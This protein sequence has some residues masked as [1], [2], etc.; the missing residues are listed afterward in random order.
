[1]FWNLVL[2]NLHSKKC[3]NVF[4]K[5]LHSFMRNSL[6]MLEKQ[7]SRKIVFMYYKEKFLKTVAIHLVLVVNSSMTPTIF[8]LIS[9]LGPVWICQKQ[10]DMRVLFSYP[11][12][13]YWNINF[14]ALI[15]ISRNEV[16]LWNALWE[17][18][19]DFQIIRRQVDQF[20]SLLVSI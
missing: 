15:S 20:D 4:F 3:K 10:M 18:N 8:Y 9:Q 14:L 19:R 5:C 17:E 11:N 12:L 6:P 13:Q 16:H 1:M 7:Q 2:S